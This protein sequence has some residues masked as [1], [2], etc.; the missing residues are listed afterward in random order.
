MI[1][2]QIPEDHKTEI[3]DSLV[4]QAAQLAIESQRKEK[5]EMSVVFVDDESM[6]N[7]NATY[8]GFDEPTDVLSFSAN[9]TDP[10]SGIV[11]VGDVVISLDTALRQAD[12]YGHLLIEE[13]QLL[14][15]HGV[16][17]LFG[18][19]HSSE[20]EKSE[21]WAHQSGILTSLGLENMSIS[22]DAH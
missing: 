5:V 22:E 10:E 18:Y 8:R 4:H 15:V 20:E 6:R 1:H 11:Y 2:I 12:K 13:I 14:V 19:D 16:L 17:H 9:E 21:M 7:L 3:D